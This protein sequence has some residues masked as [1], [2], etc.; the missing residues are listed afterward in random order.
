ME[1]T[2][3]TYIQQSLTTDGEL[4]SNQFVGRVA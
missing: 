4:S 2:E 1:E 3:T